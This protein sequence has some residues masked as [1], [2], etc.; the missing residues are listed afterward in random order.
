MTKV[1]LSATRQ[2]GLLTHSGSHNIF[3][4]SGEKCPSQ[5]VASGLLYKTLQVPICL[6]PQRQNFCNRQHMWL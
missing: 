2:K 3:S 5:K 1:L 6:Q 4:L